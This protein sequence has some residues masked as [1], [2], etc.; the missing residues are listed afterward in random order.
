MVM[1][2]FFFLPLYFFTVQKS[3]KTIEFEHQ[4][5]LEEKRQV[6]RTKAALKQSGEVRDVNADQRP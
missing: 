3:R 2:W 4:A 5:R 6:E 1:F